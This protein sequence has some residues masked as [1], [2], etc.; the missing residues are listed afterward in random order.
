MGFFVVKTTL[1]QRFLKQ[2]VA[3]SRKSSCEKSR[4]F[5]CVGEVKLIVMAENQIIKSCGGNA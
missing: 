5:F 3:F 4:A 1:N 2:R